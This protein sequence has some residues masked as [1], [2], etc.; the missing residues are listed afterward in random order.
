MVRKMISAWVD[1]EA[2]E[3]LAMNGFNRNKIIN[4]AL[5]EQAST[6]PEYVQ[7]REKEVEIQQKKLEKM[8]ATLTKLAKEK[9]E[10]RR[11]SIEE[12]KTTVTGIGKLTEHGW[13]SWAKRTG[14]SKTELKKLVGGLSE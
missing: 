5:V 10:E 9:E 8:K 7:L 1:T 4:D 3:I 2:L 11:K 6:C 13:K 12:F 14:I